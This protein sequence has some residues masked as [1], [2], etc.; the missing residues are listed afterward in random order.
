MQ[1][2]SAAQHTSLVLMPNPQQEPPWHGLVREQA[3]RLQ[4]FDV[5][6]TPLWHQ[7]PPVF[8]PQ[9]MSGPASGKRA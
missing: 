1:S 4:H 8:S 2:W 3:R 7:M 5:P 9:T 6:D